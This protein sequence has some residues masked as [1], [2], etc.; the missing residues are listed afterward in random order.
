MVQSSNH[1]SHQN[2]KELFSQHIKIPLKFR[3][4]FSGLILF[5]GWDHNLSSLEV[6]VDKSP[7]QT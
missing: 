7:N 4:V 5:F 3:F 2:L 1:Q 6:F